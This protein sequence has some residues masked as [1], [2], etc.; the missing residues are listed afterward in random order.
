MLR[1]INFSFLAMIAV[2]LAAAYFAYTKVFRYAT[3]GKRILMTALV[4]VGVFFAYPLILGQ[5]S[6]AASP[7]EA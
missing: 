3:D 6:L 1:N 7:E 4:A 5:F 2:V